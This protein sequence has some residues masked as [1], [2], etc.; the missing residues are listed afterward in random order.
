MLENLDENAEKTFKDYLCETLKR[1]LDNEIIVQEATCTAFTTMIQTKKEKLE[2]YL[3]D[4][5]KIITSV[6]DVYTGTSLLTLYDIISLLTEYFE[7][8]F[9]NASLIEDLVKCVVKKW[10]SM[11][12]SEDYK[13]I[14]PVFDMVCSIIKVSSLMVEFV[15]DFL[16]GSLRL[17]E[18]NINNYNNNNGDITVLD[19][20]VISKSLDLISV[21]CQTN[22]TII[23]Q[24]QSKAK[25][26]DL[27][28]K[29][30][31][32]GDSYVKHFV[33]ALI[34]DICNVDSE[35]LK[36]KIKQTI[37]MLI[38]NLEIPV[39]KFEALEVEKLS[40]CN[41]SCWTIGLLAISMQA[42]I[43]P[44]VAKIMKALI[45]IVSY[46]K[47]NVGLNLVK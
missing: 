11:L 42:E 33:I 21:L 24:Y 39:N 23:N 16:T 46:S 35:L 40:V 10:Y 32:T 12:N 9:K 22:P 18:I 14:S 37:E 19:R 3:F 13:N 41:N 6:F 7:E 2:P 45:K 4:I 8:H 26:V 20:E 44:Y 43:T 36:P 47:V 28:Y 1:F 38:I 5:F 27:T 31:E 30:I 29:I 17:I 15:N 34:G 25:I